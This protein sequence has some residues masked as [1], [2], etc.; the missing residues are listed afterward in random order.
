MSE[1]LDPPGAITALKYF[2]WLDLIG[3][4]IGAFVIWAKSNVFENYGEFN[5]IGAGV[6]VAVFLQGMFAWALFLVIASIAENLIAIRKK[7][8][9]TSDEVKAPANSLL[10][11][12]GKYIVEID[13]AAIGRDGDFTCRGCGSELVVEESDREGREFDC[14]VCQTK[15]RIDA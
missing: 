12:D 10:K 5:G 3:G 13:R 2:A 4:I 9:P 8:A 6:G 14:P 7:V 11:E 1:K 15:Y